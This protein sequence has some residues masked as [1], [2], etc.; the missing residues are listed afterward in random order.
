[1][2]KDLEIKKGV[3]YE[4]EILKEVSNETDF[5]LSDIKEAWR[6]HKL[7]VKSLMDDPDIIKITI[8]HLGNLYF[9]SHLAKIIYSRVRKKEL[10]K[11]LKDKLDKVVAE[12]KQ[13]FED[14][15]SKGYVTVPKYPQKRKSGAYRLYKSILTVLQGKTKKVRYTSRKNLIKVLEDYSNNRI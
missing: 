5:S 7:H 8:P 14:Y 1:M 6:I 13:H 2:S 12:V 11:P 10:F 4:D 3:K 15:K 9:N